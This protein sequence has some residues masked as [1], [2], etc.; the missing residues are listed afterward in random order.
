M[1]TTPSSDCENEAGNLTPNIQELLRM[2]E[3]V[4]GIVDLLERNWVASGWDL[5]EPTK[6]TPIPSLAGTDFEPT[7]AQYAAA[8]VFWMVVAGSGI[9]SAIDQMSRNRASISVAFSMGCEPDQMGGYLA[10]K[11]C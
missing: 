11:Y 2:K 1:N 9:H 4:D 8:V 5:S 6:E 10:D 7:A 3:E